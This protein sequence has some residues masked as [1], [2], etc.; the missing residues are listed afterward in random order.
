MYVQEAT[1][2]CFRLKT[3][4]VVFFTQVQ[5]LNRLELHRRLGAFFSPVK[6]QN[7]YADSPT[8]PEPSVDAVTSTKWVKHPSK[9]YT[10]YK[11]NVWTHASDLMFF[12]SFPRLF[13]L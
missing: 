13:T 9:I 10:H 11:S 5:G 6:P 12:L 7:R 8:S 4:C 1:Q 2:G 3:A